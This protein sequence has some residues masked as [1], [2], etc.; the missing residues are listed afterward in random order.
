[1]SMYRTWPHFASA[2]PVRTPTARSYGGVPSTPPGRTFTCVDAQPSPGA[3]H[4]A[5]GTRHDRGH[6]SAAG[7][8]D[9]GLRVFSTFSAYLHEGHGKA[10]SHGNRRSV[11][12]IKLGNIRWGKKRAATLALSSVLTLGGCGGDSPSSPKI[13]LNTQPGSF[14]SLVAEAFQTATQTESSSNRIQVRMRITGGQLD[15][16]GLAGAARGQVCLSGECVDEPITTVFA[17]GICDDTPTI[18]AGAARLGLA[19]AWLNDGVIGVDI[20]VRNMTSPGVFETTVM[21]GINRSNVIRTS[22]SPN[23]VGLFCVSR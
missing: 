13:S 12:E 10:V 15:Q 8:V 4:T 19:V 18:A 1:M 23:A 21:D 9:F 20:C 17:E 16:A 22:C 3:R 6:S 5:H 14:G 7:G 2:V 11:V